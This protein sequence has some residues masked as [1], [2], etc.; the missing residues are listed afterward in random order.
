M[1]GYAVIIEQD[2]TSF[3]AYVPA[4][5]GCV[6][7]GD[8]RAEVETLIREAIPLHIESLREHGEPVPPPAASVATVVEMPSAF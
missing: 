1:N 3:G 7:L 8:N 6:A 5:P 4:L 2:G